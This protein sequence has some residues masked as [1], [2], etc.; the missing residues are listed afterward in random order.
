MPSSF[1]PKLKIQTQMSIY[2]LPTT[3]N[4]HV[5]CPLSNIH[6][7]IHVGFIVLMFLSHGYAYFSIIF[8]TCY[9]KKW[10]NWLGIP[11]PWAQLWVSCLSDRAKWVDVSMCCLLLE[12]F[13]RNMAVTTAIS[14][15]KSMT[16][17]NLVCIDFLLDIAKYSPLMR[18]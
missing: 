4:W 1:W 9:F 16:T 7:C 10:C 5:S 13:M 6:S 18:F 17:C 12:E 2:Y 11:D 8:P 14:E 15:K 3:Y